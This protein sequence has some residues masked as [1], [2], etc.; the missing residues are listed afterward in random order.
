MVTITET[1][2]PLP[3]FEGPNRVFLTKV[4]V[5]TG[6][7]DDYKRFA[8]S[9][10]LYQSG[11]YNLKEVWLSDKVNAVTFMRVLNDGMKNPIWPDSYY[12]QSHSTM[13]LAG[14]A[15]LC[16]PAKQAE[17]VKALMARHAKFPPYTVRTYTGNVA[18]AQKAGL[19]A[20]KN[21]CTKHNFVSRLFTADRRMQY[22][23]CTQAPK[24]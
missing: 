14:D 18:D 21:P 7:E 16:V 20:T 13:F 5:D 15:T 8:E 19:K 3:E 6:N 9:L 12:Y 23:T 10:S 4:I 22:Y 17:A 1:H 11:Y 2:D 24:V